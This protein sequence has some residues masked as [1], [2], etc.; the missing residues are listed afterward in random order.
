M[1]PLPAERVM[2]PLQPNCKVAPA[3]ALAIAARSVASSHEPT[4][5]NPNGVGVAVLVGVGVLVGSATEPSN[6][7]LSHALL[8]RAIPRWSTPFTGGAAQT[9]ASPRPRAGLPA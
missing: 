3:A 8:P 4:S 5:T 7:P 9:A 6:A 1:G 2:V